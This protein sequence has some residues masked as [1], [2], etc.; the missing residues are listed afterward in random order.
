MLVI[1]NG[2]C[3]LCFGLIATKIFLHFPICNKINVPII[4]HMSIF[5]HLYIN[6]FL[7]STAFIILYYTI[8]LIVILNM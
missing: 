1:S 3:S 2:E 6:L 4:A 5:E 8:N 7:I